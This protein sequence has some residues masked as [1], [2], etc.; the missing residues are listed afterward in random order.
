[1]RER[2]VGRRPLPARLVAGTA[3]VLVL[4]TAASPVFAQDEESGGEVL[5]TLHDPRNQNPAGIAAA[6]DGDGWWIVSSA[7][8][9]DGTLSVERVGEDCNPRG[10]DEAF[11]DH[12][13]RDPQAL[14]LD[15]ENGE[16]LWVGD[17][18]DGANREWLTLNQLDLNDLPNSAVWRYVFPDGPKDVGTFLL[19]PGKKP[20]F[21]TSDAGEATLY[22]PSG[23]NQAENTPL[24]QVGTVALPDGGAVSGGA[25]NA[26][27]SKVALRTESNVYE[28]TVEGGD[29]L[30]ALGGEPAATP[31]ADSGQAEGLAYDAEGN[32]VT[33]ASEDD[34][35]SFGTVTKY[36]PAA[37]VAEEETSGGDDE[38]APASGD[39]GKSL[40]DRIL[41]LGFGTI[42]KIL[43]GIAIL[44]ML[45]MVLGIVVIRKHRKANQDGDDGDDELGFA[46]EEA[47]RGRRES[48]LADDDPVDLGLES[49]Q[50][51]PDLGEVARGNVYGG[52]RQEPSGNVYGGGGQ[53]ARPEQGGVYGGGARSEPG[54]GNVYGGGGGQQ[55]QQGRPPQGR[56][57]PQ[58]GAF[59]GGGHGSVY[60]NAGPGQS[61][62]SRQEPSGN[63]YGAGGGQQPPPRREPTGNVYGAQQ[64]R[65]QQQ[66]QQ[67]G[68]Y[69][70]GNAERTP[71]ADDGYWGPPEGGTTYGRNR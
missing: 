25:M 22:S 15:S 65:Q 18:G 29:V 61:F 58:Y 41:D 30:A 13:P 38:A 70:G 53:Q 42:V 4:V 46:A 24:D 71:D 31:V 45:V 49:G 67:G 32:F 27:G 40:V 7:D 14:V 21:V 9:Q 2:R 28:W 23:D 6:A 47:P 54:G 34:D 33:L 44:G 63:V 52:A 51:D 62:S 11:I 64:N 66:R 37:P 39:D 69:G 3:G 43:A 12:Q 50:P 48:F 26:D 20:L 55:Q 68:V 60:D 8:N 10:A 16:Y 35:G 59:E 17:I 19:L 56:Q 36:A 57:E 1:M 5:C